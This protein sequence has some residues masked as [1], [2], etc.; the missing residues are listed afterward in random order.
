M[1]K[2]PICGATFERKKRERKPPD[3]R[4]DESIKYY[5]LAFKKDTRFGFEPAINFPAARIAI[6]RVL[7][8][9]KDEEHKLI[10]DFF[11]DN[12]AQDHP[13]ITAAFSTHTVNRFLAQRKGAMNGSI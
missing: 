13:T 8:L 7:P 3:P 5:T 10:I 12:K 6:K 11:M 9:L 4:I 2:C 1:P